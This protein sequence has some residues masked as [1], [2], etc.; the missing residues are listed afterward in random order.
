MQQTDWASSA[1]EGGEAAGSRL[2]TWIVYDVFAVHDN[3]LWGSPCEAL[4][5]EMAF[6]MQ[7]S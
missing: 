5:L 4:C 2:D 3:M 7:K 1:G 6:N